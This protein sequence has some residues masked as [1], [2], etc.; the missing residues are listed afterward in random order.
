MESIQ[1]AIWNGITIGGGGDLTWS[2]PI[3]IATDNTMF[4]MPETSIGFMMGI[5]GVYFLPRMYSSRTGPGV[6]LSLTGDRIKG[7]D[8]VKWGLATHFVP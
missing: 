1:I 8:L 4:S 2:A 7:K 3:R 5:A 6:Y